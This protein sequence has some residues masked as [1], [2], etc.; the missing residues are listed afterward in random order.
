MNRVPFGLRNLN[1]HLCSVMNLI[2]LSQI[3]HWL[4][5]W[6]KFL[7]G[8]ASHCQF[9][10]QGH[11]LPCSIHSSCKGW[12]LNV[13]ISDSV[14][15]LSLTTCYTV[16]I[17]PLWWSKIYHSVHDTN[18]GAR[19]L[20]KILCTSQNYFLLKKDMI[21]D[22]IRVPK[23]PPVVGNHLFSRGDASPPAK[24]RQGKVSPCRT[25]CP[26]TRD[27]VMQHMCLDDINR[28]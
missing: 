23:F 18:L 8:R 14:C 21:W 9:K 6:G 26:Q 3:S 16:Y 19:K 13:S 28:K 17:W 15:Q 25:Q 1:S 7:T 24:A 12:E 5:S 22:Q 2:G 27:I 10:D 4:K 11:W 20:W